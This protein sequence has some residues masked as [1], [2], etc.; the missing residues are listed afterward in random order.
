MRVLRLGHF[1]F[2]YE[3]SNDDDQTNIMCDPNIVF[4]I[5]FQ[6]RIFLL[7]YWLWIC[8]SQD[9]FDKIKP[10]NSSNFML[11]KTSRRFTFWLPI[12]MFIYLYF[13]FETTLLKILLWLHPICEEKHKFDLTHRTYLCH[14]PP[15]RDTA[16]L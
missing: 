3:I 5:V 2:Q 9:I 13:Y 12:W 1:E 10:N 15:S 4:N 11:D 6:S 7:T 16:L 14:P 8:K